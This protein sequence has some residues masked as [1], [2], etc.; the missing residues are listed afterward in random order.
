MKSFYLGLTAAVVLLCAGCMV[1][2]D[3]FKALGAGVL[4][5][6]EFSEQDGVVN[7]VAIV[8]QKTARA[9]GLVFPPMFL[10]RADEVIE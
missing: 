6:R 8:N 3:Y 9:L 10:A 4:A 7:K 2:P 5:G 1:G